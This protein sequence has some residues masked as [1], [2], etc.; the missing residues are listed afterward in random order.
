MFMYIRRI[1]LK[2]VKEDTS[3]IYFA[4]NYQSVNLLCVCTLTNVYGF[5]NIAK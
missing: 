5:K 2:T 1:S 4:L 3:I